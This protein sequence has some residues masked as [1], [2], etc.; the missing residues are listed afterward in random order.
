VLSLDVSND[1][2]LRSWILSF[3]PLARVLSPAA[4]VDQIRTEIDT[5]S[6]RYAESDLR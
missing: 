5:A 3:G 4:L 2:A 1:W 6:G